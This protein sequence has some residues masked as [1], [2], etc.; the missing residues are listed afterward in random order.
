MEVQALE[1][2]GDYKRFEKAYVRYRQTKKPEYMEYIY[3]NIKDNFIKFEELILSRN[4]KSDI[5]I[6]TLMCLLEKDSKT[7]V[8]L[9][10]LLYIFEEWMQSMHL[11]WF[12]IFTEAF[13]L[14]MN[15]FFRISK[16]YKSPRHLAYFIS[17]DMKMFVFAKIR[18]I[19][20]L[21]RRDISLTNS[22]RKEYFL[23]Q[24]KVFDPIHFDSYSFIKELEQ[25]KKMLS[26]FMKQIFNKTLNK[27]DKEYLCHSI[28]QKLLD[29]LETTQMLPTSNPL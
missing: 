20:F 22:K 24:E 25:N 27:Q 8:S 23:E 19:Y 12:D 10:R 9:K 26:I 7:P 6:Y 13:L 28:S 3:K 4:Y 5:T 18:N 16:W 11:T 29:N 15:K 1:F 14:H 17:L 2:K 21:K